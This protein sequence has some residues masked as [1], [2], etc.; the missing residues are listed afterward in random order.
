MKENLK[1]N[2]IFLYVIFFLS[3]GQFNE[4][5]FCQNGGSAYVNEMPVLEV[6]SRMLYF[7]EELKDISDHISQ[8]SPE[9]LANA[10]Q[11]I[12]NA[13]VKWNTYCQSKQ[14]LIAEDDSLLQI[15]V[16][17]QTTKQNLLDSIAQ[18][19]SFYDSQE[20]FNEAE[21]FINNQ[22]SIYKELYNTALEYSLIKS[23][24]EELEKLKGKEEI[25]SSEL[26]EKYEKAKSISQEYGILQQR[27]NKIE[28]KYIELKGISE[29]IKNMK[30]QPFIQRIKD[31]LY[32]IAAVA[33][34]LMF[35]NMIQAKIKSI[36]QAR[37][38]AK[39]MMEMMNKDENDYPVI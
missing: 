38:N 2:I 12:A 27:F 22:D 37:E 26:Q 6:E 36:K 31:Y 24:A 18:K 17:F 19:F 33:M 39:K 11:K 16:N 13:E 1:H 21:S 7:Y 10:N 23:L 5:A 35:I 8:Y 3:I 25:L 28:E 32:S 34:I 15:V 30:Y 29:K 14:E 4:K 20:T 9:E